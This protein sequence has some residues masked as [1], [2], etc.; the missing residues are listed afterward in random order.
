MNQRLLVITPVNNEA[1]HIERT[2]RAVAAQLHTPKLWIVVDDG[3]DDGTPAILDRLQHEIPFLQVLRAPQRSEHAGVRDRLAVAKEALAFNWAAA[4]V[5]V[6][7]YTHVG[8]LDGDVELP[9]EWYA[10]LLE[11]FAEDP[12]LGVA[13]GRL[14]EQGPNGWFPLRVPSY[15]VHGA[16]KVY[17][18]R[19]FDAIG[20]IQER[21]GWDTIDET[22]ARMA[23]WTS[24]SFGDLIARHHRSWGS[25]DG[26]LRGCARHG[27]CAYVLCYG[28]WWV[29]PRALKVA[30][31]RPYGLSG[32]AF[33]WGYLASMARGAPRVDDREFRRFV[34]KEL[35]QRVLSHGRLTA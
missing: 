22:Y 5:D 12:Q 15:H 27:E 9:P 3:S 28:P 35:R 33:A 8:K 34:R 30:R 16:V 24:R 14:Q 31:R 18:R 11:R 32:L 4:Q 20:G 17:D 25:A 2:A 21:L 6:T 26:R 7:A 23:G 19:C 29:L 13:G 10:T 1:A